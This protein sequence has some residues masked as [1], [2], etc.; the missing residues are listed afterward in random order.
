VL[1]LKHL[2]ERVSNADEMLVNRARH[3]LAEAPR[4]TI[5]LL[6]TPSP[7]LEKAGRRE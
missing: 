3:L 6:G 5:C 7:E 2:R 4:V 1:E